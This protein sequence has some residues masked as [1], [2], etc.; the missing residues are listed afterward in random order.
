VGGRP[1]VIKPAIPFILFQQSTE[2]TEKL[3]NIGQ[4]SSLQRK[5]VPPFVF[6]TLRTKHQSLTNA[7]NLRSVKM[8][9]QPY[10]FD[11]KCVHSSG[12]LLRLSKTKCSTH[13]NLLI[14][15]GIVD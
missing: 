15:N 5:V 2:L 14:R 12:I 13:E 6:K 10:C 4:Y 8:G 7:G 3:D 1:T 9:F 11:C